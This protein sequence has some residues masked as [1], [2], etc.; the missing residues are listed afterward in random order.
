MIPT[1]ARTDLPNLI[2][3]LPGPRAQEL[4][5]RDH[6]VLSPSYTRPYPLVVDHGEGAIVEDVDGNRF[7]DFNAGIAV[8]AT[9]HSHPRVVAAIQQQAA[10]LLHMSG[11]DFYYANMVELAEKL[12]AVAPVPAPRRVYFGNSGTEAIEAAMKMARYSTGRQH[13]IAFF[14]SFHGRTLGA[15]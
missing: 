5:A 15:L 2:T 4:I 12:A 11:T 6:A 9:G 13:F 10:K 3:P 8:V 1:G 14:G 7:L